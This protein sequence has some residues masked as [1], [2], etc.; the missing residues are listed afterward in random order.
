MK[1]VPGVQ[2]NEFISAEDYGAAVSAIERFW[3]FIG[4]N[5]TVTT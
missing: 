4:E 2:N 3:E 1:H 5:E